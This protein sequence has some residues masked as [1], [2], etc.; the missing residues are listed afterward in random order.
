[1]QRSSHIY[2]GQRLNKFGDGGICPSQPWIIGSV[3]D[4]FCSSGCS[5]QWY[6]EEIDINDHLCRC[7]VE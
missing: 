7:C 4:L 5:I 6:T 3:I 1:M 2:A